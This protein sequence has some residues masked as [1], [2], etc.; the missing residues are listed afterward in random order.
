VKKPIGLRSTVATLTI[1]LTLLAIL[2]SGAL[3]ALTTLLHRSTSHSSTSVES[4]RLADEAELNLLLHERAQD[5][6]V[7]R[8]IEHD[9]RRALL[10]AKQ[11]VTSD[12]EARAL[13]VAE[14]E[15]DLYGVVSRDPQRSDA[16][17]NAQQQAAYGALT[18]L[19]TVNTAQAAAS[20]QQAEQLDRLGNALGIAGGL[21]L[22]AIAGTLLVWLKRR[23]FEP[24]FALVAAMERFGSG[25]HDARAAER[26][27]LELRDICVHFNRMAS[28]IASQRQAQMAFLGG[29]AHDL[30]GPLAVLRVA[31]AL[32]DRDTGVPSN[33]DRQAI[34][35]IQRQITRMDR[36]LVDF[37]DVSRIEA[38]QLEMRFDTCDARKLVMDAIELFETT[39]LEHLLEVRIPDGV[40]PFRCDHL[41]IE[42]ALI[43]LISNAIKY[44][45]AGSV[46]SVI[47]ESREDELELSV[48]DHGMGITEEDRDCIFEPFRRVGP[49]KEKVPGVGLGLYIVR[50]IVEAHQG[51]IEM[52]STPNEGS[53]FRVF[54]PMRHD[55]MEAAAC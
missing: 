23:A 17:R 30:R 45:A 38:G 46:V 49:S 18:A 27:P 25:D 28:A 44:S 55:T 1:T 12:L 9:I 32:I 6:L 22:V 29:V 24:I 10:E 11:F 21:C 37:I 42:Q 54:L 36:M 50:K 53:S 47:L 20:Q 34:Q 41:R 8:Q 35:R 15:T 13:T 14:R 19:V 43:N 16:E 7:K 48:C 26:G 39:P 52:E 3:V 51:R 33:G 40:I 31:V 4:I 5:P 2:V